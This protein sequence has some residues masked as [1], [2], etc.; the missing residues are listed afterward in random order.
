MTDISAIVQCIWLSV[1]ACDI[2]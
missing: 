1:Y 2:L